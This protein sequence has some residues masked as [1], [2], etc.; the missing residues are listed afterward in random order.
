MVSV[1][2]LIHDMMEKGYLS[3]DE[4]AQYLNSMHRASKL[5]NP[6]LTSSEIAIFCKVARTK[7]LV[8]YTE[9]DVINRFRMECSRAK[10]PVNQMLTSLMS[11]F[12]AE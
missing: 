11:N 9:A 5:I 12:I 4:G 3:Y 7:E 1:T 2:A 8:V 6:D 10:I